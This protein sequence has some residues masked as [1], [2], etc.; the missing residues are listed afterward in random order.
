MLKIIYFARV[1]TI[2]S[3]G[4]IFW[5]N[6]SA[7]NKVFLMQKKSSELLQMQDLEILVE[8]FSVICK[9]LHFIPNTYSLY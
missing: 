3:Y 8:K 5:G 9:Y 1:H 6:T 4:I 7:A 2:M